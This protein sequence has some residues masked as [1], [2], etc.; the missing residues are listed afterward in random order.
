M[1]GKFSDAAAVGNR[2]VFAPANAD[3]VGVYDVSS[4]TF[5]ASV[6]TGSLIWADKFTGAVAVGNLVVFAPYDADAV[7]VY[8]VIS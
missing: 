2:V 4:A 5:D 3:A 8:D 1:A 6:S 7:G